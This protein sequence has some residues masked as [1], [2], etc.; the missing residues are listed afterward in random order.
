VIRQTALIYLSLP[1]LVQSSLNRQNDILKYIQ[2]YSI[3]LVTTDM[4]TRWAQL[5]FNA[6]KEKKNKSIEDLQYHQC[7]QYI[8]TEQLF[9]TTAA[10]LPQAPL[11]RDKALARRFDKAL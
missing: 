10:N 7:F 11:P 6:A 5:A 8:P 1:F 9:P 2:K 3:G 4:S